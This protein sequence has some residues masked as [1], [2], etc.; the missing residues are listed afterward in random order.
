VAQAELFLEAIN[1]QDVAAMRSNM[2][3]ARG[4]SAAN[5]DFKK[6]LKELDNG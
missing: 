6:M 3:A 1:R 4:A 5:K 2:I